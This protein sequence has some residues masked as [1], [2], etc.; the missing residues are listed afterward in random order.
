[1]PKLTSMFYRTTF[2]DTASIKPALAVEPK[3]AGKDDA[4]FE[5]VWLTRDQR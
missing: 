5:F 3:A 4:G 2:L 1:M